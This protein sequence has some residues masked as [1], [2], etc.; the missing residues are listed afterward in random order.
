MYAK[1][2][3]MEDVDRVFSWMKAKDMV[4]WNSL[5]GALSENYM[6]EDARAVFEKMPCH[7]VVSWTAIISAYVQA[8][9]GSEALNLFIQMMAEGVTP[10]SPTI[11]SLLTAC[12]SLCDT[13]LGQQ[14]HCLAVK[15][16]LVYE[17]FVG[18][19]L[20]AM[21]FNCGATESFSVFGEMVDCDIVTWNSML[22]GC[23]QHGLGRKAIEMFSQMK[24]EGISPNHASFVPLLSACSH[25]GLVEEGRHYFHSMSKQYG[26]EP[27]NGH[28]ASMVDLLGRAGHLDEAEALI[29]NMPIQPDAVVWRALLGA[30]RIHRNAETGRRAAERLFVME[31]RNC[32]NYVL[33]SNLYACLGMWDE[34]EKVRRLMRE[35]GVRKEPGCS[36][37][38]IKGKLHC[39]ITGDNKHEHFT[40]INDALKELYDRFKGSGYAPDTSFALHDVEEE[41]KE[42]SILHH[43][44]KLAVAYALQKTSTELPILIMKNIRICGDCHTFI[45]FVSKIFKREI[46]VRD[47]K[48]FHH[49]KDGLCSCGD[50]W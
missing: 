32:S 31:P 46:N 16:G 19:C 21:Y 42:S 3:K 36:W 39:F 43:S 5:I 28:Y 33:L 41:Q 13:K 9:H 14:I 15:L 1:C 47:G 17:L 10:C 25:S 4:S 12:G 2:K 24:A 22:V 38:Q 8:E 29:C 50:Y 20:I 23:A 26:L 49:I 35:V 48:R 11:A 45:K 37:M 44:E 6:L 18:N 40:E 27:L 30:C 34:V 7:D